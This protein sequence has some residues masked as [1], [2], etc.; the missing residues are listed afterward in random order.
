MT[1]AERAAGMARKAAEREGRIHDQR[2]AWW[3]V[4]PPGERQRE[5]LFSP[6]Q[7]RS[8]VL[9]FYPGATVT[10]MPDPTPEQT[11]G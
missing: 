5:V 1:P 6:A 10:P 9:E 7:N 4:E 11:T 3:T 2:A 8:G